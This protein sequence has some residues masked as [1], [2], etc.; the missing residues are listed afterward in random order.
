[1]KIYDSDSTVWDSFL[2]LEQLEQRVR[3]L[4]KACR[5]IVAPLP[6]EQRKVLEECFLA[7]QEL[8]SAQIRLSY[9]SGIQ[10]GERR[11]KR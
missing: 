11:G 9:V 3:K 5:E 4:E 8:L 6:E 1:M 7:H 2:P 10:V